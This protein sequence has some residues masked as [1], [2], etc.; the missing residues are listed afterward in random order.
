[1]KSWARLLAGL[2]VLL[3]LCGGMCTTVYTDADLAAEERKQEKAAAREE[4]NDRQLG[5]QG[6]ANE[7]AIREQID[8]IDGGSGADF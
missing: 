8:Q 1:M 4:K 6:G 5:E 3:A 2:V 7:E